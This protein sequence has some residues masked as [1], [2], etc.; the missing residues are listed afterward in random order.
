MFNIVLLCVFLLLF[1]GGC[2]GV[3]CDVV[4]YLC[5]VI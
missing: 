4:V 2:V 3:C 5:W 1:V